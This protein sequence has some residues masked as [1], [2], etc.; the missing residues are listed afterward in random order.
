MPAQCAIENMALL[1]RLKTVLGGEIPLILWSYGLGVLL[2]PDWKW[3]RFSPLFPVDREIWGTMFFLAGLFGY[4]ALYLLNIKLWRCFLLI[5]VFLFISS[6]V[7]NWGDWSDFFIY[8]SLGYC[9]V[10]R[11]LEINSSGFVK[12]GIGKSR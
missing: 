6:A 11:F 1:K 3:S 4:V 5:G 2:K 7:Y 8:L 9:C 12:R 10:A